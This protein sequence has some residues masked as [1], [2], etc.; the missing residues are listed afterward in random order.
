MWQ[1]PHLGNISFT[2]CFTLISC[3]YESEKTLLKPTVVER[4]WKRSRICMFWGS[5]EPGHALLSQRSSIS[6]ASRG[7]ALRE[8]WHQKCFSQTLDGCLVLLHGCT[9]APRPCCSRSPRGPCRAGCLPTICFPS[10]WQRSR[11]QPCPC[12]EDLGGGFWIV[13]PFRIL[14]WVH[15]CQGL[16]WAVGS[17]RRTPHLRGSFMSQPTPNTNVDWEAVQELMVCSWATRA[18]NNNL[19]EQKCWMQP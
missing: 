15:S 5:K 18:Q 11:V 12:P 14:S 17:C 4:E 19:T 7:R 13:L 2:V 10:H 6:T 16:C 3:G 9:S 1:Q 8:G